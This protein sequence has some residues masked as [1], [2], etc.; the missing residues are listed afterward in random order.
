MKLI[1]HKGTNV[2][3]MQFA[4][5]AAYKRAV[6]IVQDKG[7][8]VQQAEDVQVHTYKQFI[9][10]AA[11]HLCMRDPYAAHRSLTRALELHETMTGAQRDLVQAWREG[12][13]V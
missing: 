2:I 5:E 8:T 12:R 10:S 9:T 6:K 7:Y 3:D 1:A 13:S 4:D 11:M